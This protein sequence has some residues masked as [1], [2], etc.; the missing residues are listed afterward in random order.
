[1]MKR[2]EHV[3]GDVELRHVYGVEV[4]VSERRGFRAIA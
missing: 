4:G 1:M 2:L 3:A